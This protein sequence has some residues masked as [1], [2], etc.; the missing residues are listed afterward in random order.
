MF[1][2]RSFIFDGISS[3]IYNLYINDLSDGSPVK[4]AGSSGLEVY[5]E[6]VYRKSIP[7]YFGGTESPKLSYEFSCFSEQEIDANTAGL[8]QKWLFGQRSYKKFQVDQID[9]IPYYINGLFNSPQVNKVGNLIREFSATLEANAP[10]AFSFPQTISQTYD[11]SV[12]TDQIIFNN[13]S[14]D[15]SDYLQPILTIIM[16]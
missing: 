4:V 10:F 15:A 5:E 7:Y 6:K 2:G 14:D 9:S 16:N 8:I 3:E 1:Y 13:S 12:V 11:S